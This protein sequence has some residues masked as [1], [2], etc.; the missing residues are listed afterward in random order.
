MESL[1]EDVI[2]YLYKKCF[3]LVFFQDDQMHYYNSDQ[4]DKQFDNCIQS[5]IEN[6]KVLG[7]SLQRNIERASVNMPKV[8]DEL[9]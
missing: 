4:H 1:Q 9:F 8:D 2:Q 7:E 6:S 3:K 5:Y